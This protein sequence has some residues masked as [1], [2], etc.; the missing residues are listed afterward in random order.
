[1]DADECTAHDFVTVGKYSHAAAT[2][3]YETFEGWWDRLI[4]ALRTPVELPSYNANVIGSEPLGKD[5]RAEAVAEVL[6]VPYGGQV[7]KS[8]FFQKAVQF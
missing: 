6:G 7:D 4:S 5:R 3:T 2:M 8:W 1:V